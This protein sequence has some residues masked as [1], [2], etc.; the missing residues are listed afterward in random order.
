M[1]LIFA[2]TGG[3]GAG[4]QTGDFAGARY[5]VCAVC[6]GDVLAC[7]VV[8][9]VGDPLPFPPEELPKNIHAPPRITAA[10]IAPAIIFLSIF[11][12]IGIMTA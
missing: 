4:R 7:G 12:F 5:G 9:A 8:V 10:P 6:C 1:P 2:A 11:L 3:F